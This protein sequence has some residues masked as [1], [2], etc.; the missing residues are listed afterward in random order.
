[1]SHAKLFY[2][3]IFCDVHDRFLYS[4][5]RAAPGVCPVDSGHSVRTGSESYIF[6]LDA[7]VVQF[8]D[9]PVALQSAPI[10]C[11]TSS[12]SIDVYLSKI[13]RSQGRHHVVY[14]SGAANTITVRGWNG[15]E[16]IDGQA[17]QVLSATDSFL[18]LSNDGVSEWSVENTAEGSSARSFN[19]GTLLTQN[20]ERSAVPPTVNDDVGLGYSVGFNWYDTASDK[21]YIC[22]DNARGAAEWEVIQGANDGD[23]VDAHLASTSNPHSVSKA[24]VGLGNVA[25]TKNK[26]DAVAPPTA[27][28]DSSQG[29]S[30]GSAWVDLSADRSYVCVDSAASAAVWRETS[31]QNSDADHTQLANVGTNTHA[32][33]DAHLADSTIHRAINDGGTSGTE[34]WSASKISSQLGTKAAAAHSHAAS[35]VVSGAF[36]DARISASSVTQHAGSISHQSLSGSGTNTHAQLDSH[37]SSSSNPHSVTKAQL[38]LGNVPDTKVKLDG[39]A[40]PAATDDSSQGF[41]VGSIWCDVVSDK[42]FACLDATPSAAVWVEITQQ[43]VDTTDHTALTN[44]GTNSHAAIDAHLADADKHREINDSASTSTDLWSASKIASELSLK[45]GAAHSH[46]SGDVSDFAAAADARADARIAAQRGAADGIASLDSGGKVPA[47][48]LSLSNVVYQGGWNA[49]TNTPTLTSSVGTQGHYYVVTTSGTTSIDSVASWASGD[50]IIFNGSAWEKADHTDSVTSVAG[51]QGAVSLVKA[52]VGLANVDDTS[53]ADKPVSTATQAALDAKEP[54]FAKNSGFNLVLGTSAG[55]VSEGNHSHSGP[56][57]DSRVVESNVT[58][59]VAALAHQSLSGS[60]ANTHAQIDAHVASSANPHSVT[61]AQVGLS[62]L[63]NVKRKL[64]A[65]T[66]P[67]SSNDS[68]EG[69][70]VGS[71]WFDQTANCAYVCLDDSVGAAVWKDISSATGS[72]DVVG[73]ASAADHSVPRFDGTTG[74][75]LQGPTSGTVSYADDASFTL[76]GSRAGYMLDVTNSLVSGGAAGVSVKAGELSGDVALHV[77]DSSDSLTVMEVEAEQGFVTFGKTY[78]QTLADHGTVHGVDNQHPGAAS[79]FNTQSGLYR[80]AGKACA[81]MTEFKYAEDEELMATTSTSFVQALRITTDSVPAGDYRIGWQYSWSTTDK[82]RDFFGRVEI[83]DSTTIHRMQNAP[84]N[85]YADNDQAQATSGFKRVTLAAGTHTI[86]LDYHVQTSGA[87][88]Q[89]WNCRLEIWR[90]A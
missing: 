29:F 88:A 47:S 69:F 82:T 85:V 35:E 89:I 58:Q 8:A 41:S 63:Q 53:D 83:D 17:S 75:L 18:V 21:Q 61:K 59:H 16:L 15:A 66:A 72:G 39:T 50:W 4:F 44:V 32:Q 9:G 48:Q 30:V 3:R 51:K 12:G 57:P 31:Q 55:T 38:G 42:A 34:L 37:V 81:M 84:E 80:I 40:A 14:K 10:I 49:S 25:N 78:A 43:N 54:A 77:G 90:I 27:A 1:M 68:S 13:E 23:A 56:L 45:A 70:S 7:R 76:S 65:T 46:S 19:V 52:D 86:D 36:A 74:K 79:D 28:D 24:Q 73:P 22:T 5:S 64:D 67:Q 11:D 60:G 87:S 33:I 62:N 2:Y 6:S 26:F 71:D 20:Y